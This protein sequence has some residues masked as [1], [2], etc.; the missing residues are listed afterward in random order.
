MPYGMIPLKYAHAN[1]QIVS[2]QHID[3]KNKN[4]PEPPP[5]SRDWLILQKLMG[6]DGGCLSICCGGG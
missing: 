1:L 3:N 4:E 2:Q 6:S 5:V